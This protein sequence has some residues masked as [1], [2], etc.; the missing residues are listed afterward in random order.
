[1]RGRRGTERTVHRTVPV[2]AAA[3]APWL[4]NTAIAFMAALL[5]MP[6]AMLRDL[7]AHR[8][9]VTCLLALVASGTCAPSNT[10]LVRLRCHSI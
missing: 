5:A 4:S 7:S 9:A 2:L 3:L 10:S 6:V 1:M 8:R